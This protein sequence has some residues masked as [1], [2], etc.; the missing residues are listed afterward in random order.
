M[1]AVSKANFT[2]PQEAEA[3]F[4]RA[5][6]EGNFEALMEVWSEEDEVV[7]VH[8]G[9][10]RIVGLAAVH[11]TWRRILS[12]DTRLE[13]ELTQSVAT[14]SATM[15]VHCVVERLSVHGQTK[16]SAVLAATNVFVRGAH[17]WRM[18]LH[19]ASPMQDQADFG[20]LSPRVVH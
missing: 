7:C 13:I 5:L 9:G 11:E 15:A 4:Y 6:A 3:A 8:P 2:T 16:R 19:H 10:P 20:D 12:G 18:V 14:V 17:G 1:P